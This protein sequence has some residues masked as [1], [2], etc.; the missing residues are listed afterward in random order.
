MLENGADVNI[1]DDNGRTAFELAIREGN[2][3]KCSTKY[4]QHI[5]ISLLRLFGSG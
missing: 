1:K 4:F 2:L 5:Y 3:E